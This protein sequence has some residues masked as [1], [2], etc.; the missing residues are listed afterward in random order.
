MSTAVSGAR[1]TSAFMARPPQRGCRGLRPTAMTRGL[2]GCRRAGF[3]RH[4][5]RACAERRC[6]GAWSLRTP[7]EQLPAFEDLQRLVEPVRVSCG[8]AGLT[9][10]DKNLLLRGREPA[11]R[12]LQFERID[13]AVLDPDRIGYAGDGAGGLQDRGLNRTT[14]P[15]IR[16]G[17][18]EDTGRGALAV[19]PHD[20][21]LEG[22]LG[23]MPALTGGHR[24]ASRQSMQRKPW[25]R[26]SAFKIARKSWMASPRV[27]SRR[28]RN[29]D[30]WRLT[31]GKSTERPLP[32]FSTLPLAEMNPARRNLL[33]ACTG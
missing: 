7:S 29:C 17:K 6:R 22:V 11:A 19:M 26:S 23:A 1:R 32:A 5:R 31:V 27:A 28:R 24:A 15:A 25:R 20:C 13:L 30:G 9:Q 18:H 21:T 33:R 10:L 14:T 2:V 12:G 16:H 8:R 4:R 3:A